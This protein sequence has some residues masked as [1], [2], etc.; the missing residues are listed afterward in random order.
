MKWR[1]AA[2]IADGPHLGC[3]T[4]HRNGDKG[5]KTK[6]GGLSHGKPNSQPHDAQIL[7]VRM[8]C[9]LLGALVSDKEMRAGG[10]FAALEKPELMLA[11]YE[12]LWTWSAGSDK[13]PI[14]NVADF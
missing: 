6:V 13:T 14:T 10:Y 3:G 7:P 5:S 12:H 8:R 11:D 9:P 4:W 1:R 2:G